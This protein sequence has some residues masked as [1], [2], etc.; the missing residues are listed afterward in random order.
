MNRSSTSQRDVQRVHRAYRAPLTMFVD[1][2][3]HGQLREEFSEI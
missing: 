2:V 1:C 3:E